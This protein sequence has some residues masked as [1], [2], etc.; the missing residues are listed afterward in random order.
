MYPYYKNLLSKSC[1]SKEEDQRQIVLSLKFG[2][3]MSFE[4]KINI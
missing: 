1:S 3:L 4:I 2:S